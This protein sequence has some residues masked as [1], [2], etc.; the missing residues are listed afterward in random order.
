MC[1]VSS[2]H[3]TS[4][5]CS[6]FNARTVM[7]SKFPIGVATMYKCPG[8]TTEDERVENENAVVIPFQYLCPFAGANALA[9]LNHVPYF[10]LYR[11]SFRGCKHWVIP[12]ILVMIMIAREMSTLLISERFHIKIVQYSVKTTVSSFVGITLKSA[13]QVSSLHRFNCSWMLLGKA[14]CKV[15][16][17]SRLSKYAAV[18]TT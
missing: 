7:S 10:P 13:W 8:E 2:V 16:S 15:G 4:T 12:A 3:T 17:S 1:L 18:S 11:P 9:V 6:T 14:G 5:C